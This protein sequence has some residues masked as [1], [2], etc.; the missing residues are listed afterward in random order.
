[1]TALHGALKEIASVEENCVRMLVPDLSGLM[2]K[3]SVASETVAV[4]RFMLPASPTVFVGL[5]EST[6]NVICVQNGQVE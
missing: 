1:M 4:I 6:V 3:T 5:F 2:N